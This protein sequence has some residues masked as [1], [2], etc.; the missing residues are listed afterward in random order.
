MN[1]SAEAEFRA[2]GERSGVKLDPTRSVI[3]N[4]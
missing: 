4:E 2:N 3:D 1:L